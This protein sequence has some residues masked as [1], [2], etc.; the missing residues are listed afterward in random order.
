MTISFSIP[1]GFKAFRM[2]T[3]DAETIIAYQ[4]NCQM[5]VLNLLSCSKTEMYP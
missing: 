2:P 5:K 3:G 1:G 4:E